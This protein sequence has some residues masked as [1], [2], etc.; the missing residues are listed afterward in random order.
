M[1]TGWDLTALT[2]NDADSTGERR[3]QGRRRSRSSP[4]ETVTCTFTDTKRGTIV[5]K[6]AT[7]PSPDPT[8]RSSRTRAPGRA[9]SRN[10]ATLTD[11][12]RARHVHVDADRA[13]PAGACRASLCTDADST[14][15]SPSRTATFKVSAGETVTCTFTDTKLPAACSL[16]YPSG[17]APALSSVVFTANQVIKATAYLPATNQLAVWF[18]G[19]YA[20]TTGIRQVVV[21]TKTGTTTTN[22]PATAMGANPGRITS[23]GLYG[24][25]ILGNGLKSPNENPQA[26][27]DIGTWTS[28]YGYLDSN[29]P[30]WPGI[31]VTDI[32]TN[33]AAVTGDWQRGGTG[34]LPTDVFG[35][36]KLAVKTVDQTATPHKIDVVTDAEPA[37][38]NWTLGTGSD[39][40]AGG[41]ARAPE[42]GL[43]RRAALEPRLARPPAGPCVP[44]PGAPAQAGRLPGADLHERVHPGRL[45]RIRCDRT[46]RPGGASV[47]AGAFEHRAQLRAARCR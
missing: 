44:A 15:S 20:L 18:N 38:N 13:R 33:A 19:P 39:T 22:Y 1:P 31:Y 42:H 29:R 21:K 47:V 25:M 4:G 11:D 5:V 8:T 43:R 34:R 46:P 2:C 27:T 40:P 36:W 16:G 14:G 17:S 7:N 12:R 35:T 10:G 9:R 24:S 32:T 6:Q 45:T 23:T 30:W 37:K 26:G 3:D 41:F 28:A